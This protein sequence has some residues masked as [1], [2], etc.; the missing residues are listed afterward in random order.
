[1]T[2]FL[3]SHKSNVKTFLKWIVNNINPKFLFFSASLSN[4]LPMA[5]SEIAAH[6]DIKRDSSFLFISPEARKTKSTSKNFNWKLT[7]ILEKKKISQY[8]YG[9]EVI[10]RCQEEVSWWEYKGKF[11]QTWS[12]VC[13]SSQTA[14]MHA[15]MFFPALHCFQ[16]MLTLGR[17]TKFFKVHFFWYWI[18]LIWNKH[19]YTISCHSYHYIFSR[20]NIFKKGN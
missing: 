3:I 20:R 19:K 2:A 7:K 16:P 17:R 6:T 15:L 12:A 18:K 8:Q 11:F 14:H 13:H 1:M 10:M 4:S 5:L 9:N